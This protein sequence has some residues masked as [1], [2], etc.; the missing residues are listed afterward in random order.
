M[1]LFLVFG[2]LFHVICIYLRIVV[3]YMSWLHKLLVSYKKQELLTHHTSL[4]VESVLFIFLVFYVVFF[5][6]SSS[7]YFLCPMLPASLDCLVFSNI[8]LSCLYKKQ[9][10]HSFPDMKFQG[11]S[12]TFFSFQGYIYEKLCSTT[13]L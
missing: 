9:G 10:S 13:V 1:L 4:M 5:V 7:F 12:R 6:W 8:Y 3:S 2:N 11:F